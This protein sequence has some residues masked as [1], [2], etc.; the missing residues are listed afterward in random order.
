MPRIG[1]D[2]P[3]IIIRLATQILISAL[4]S[5]NSVHLVALFSKKLARSCK[6]QEFLLGTKNPTYENYNRYAHYVAQ[7]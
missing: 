7:H 2:L 3:T 4:N 6:V 5:T 1:H